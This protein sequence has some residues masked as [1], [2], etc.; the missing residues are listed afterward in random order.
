[1]TQ[2][3]QSKSIRAIATDVDGT[4]LN[5]QHRLSPGN[6]HAL[7]RAMAQGIQVIIAT[8]K[9]R[10]SAEAVIEQLALDTPG[11]YVQ[12]LVL[13]DGDG[14]IRHE[15]TLPADVARQIDTLTSDDGYTL[16]AYSRDRIYM[17]RPR[18]EWQQ[19]LVRY[20]EPR[21]EVVESMAA[22]LA[23]RQVNKLVVFCEQEHIGAVREHLTCH[24]DGQASLVQAV[25]AMLEVMP[26][27]ASKGEGLKRLL[28]DLGIAPEHVMA[29]GDGENDVEMLRLAGIGV[30][31]GNA[32]EAAR[33]AADV[34]VATNEADGVAE[35][36][37]RFVLGE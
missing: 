4:L 16:I 21:A 7:R 29:I 1:M 27:G 30:A 8:G 22:L 31:V 14:S 34:V 13:T 37:E 24:V 12:G 3:I 6:E 5:N 10:R 32:M 20:H 36:I 23:E 19:M 26:P 25:P 15:R 2:P 33:A 11:V 9:S 28:D 17:I 18:E 35:A